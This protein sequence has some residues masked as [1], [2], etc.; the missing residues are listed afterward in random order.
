M[1]DLGGRIIGFNTGCLRE[2]F[3]FPGAAGKI[4]EIGCNAL[5]ISLTED[6][7]KDDWLKELKA[8]DLS[9]FEHVSL[10]A[11][12][13][14][15]SG[16]EK[17]QEILSGI[18]RFNENVRRLDLI[19]IHPDTISDF[20]GLENCGLPIGMENM[21]QRK[22]THRTIE[23]MEK[24]FRD[25]AGFSMVLDVN[26]AFVNDPSYELGRT[27]VK[28][29]EDK[30]KEVHLSGFKTLHDPLFENEQA[31]LVRTISELEVPIIIESDIN[32]DTMVRELQYILDN[33][34]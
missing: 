7:W 1:I 25:F 22:K 17:G 12:K 30:I 4:R 14:D 10:H 3:R 2:E 33:L 29:F 28:K 20:S 8:E 15:F 27:F 34:K 26:H 18:K 21:D 32:S 19:V 5:E 23:D 11:P 9:G 24:L 13:L 6:R 31:E 16:G